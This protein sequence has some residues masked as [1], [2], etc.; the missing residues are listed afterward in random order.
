MQKVILSL[1]ILVLFFCLPVVSLAYETIEVKNGGSIEG[2]VE[3]S[4]AT[5]P[6]D[7]TIALSSE[8]EYCG[9][10]LPA[11]KYLISAERRIKNVVV[12]IKEIKA[13]RAIPGDAVT[14]TNLKCSFVPH[15]AVGFKGNKFIMKN[16]DPIFH[17]FDVHA[18]IGGMEFYSGSFHEKGATVTKTLPKPGLLE[19]SC[20]VHPWQHA[21]VYIFDQPYTAVTNEKGE[22]VIKGVPPGI[23]T[24]EAWHETMGKTTLSNVKVKSGE[25]SRIKLEYN[26]NVNLE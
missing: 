15:V 7:E 11:E 6:K 8:L 23:Y 2:I 14:V 4:G 26:L 22:F 17:T 24:I 21:Y 25:T 5:I 12:F 9:K 20:Y 13:G 16:D 19:L 10:N 18:Y 3:F 1:S